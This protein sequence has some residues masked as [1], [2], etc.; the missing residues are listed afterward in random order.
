MALAP[1]EQAVLACPSCGAALPARWRSS[2]RAEPTPGYTRTTGPGDCFTDGV[3]VDYF[4]DGQKQVS[5]RLPESDVKRCP[6]CQRYFWLRS[7][8][9]LQKPLPDAVEAPATVAPLGQGP[10]C[11]T[12]LPAA[13]LFDAI[14]GGLARDRSEETTL[15]LLAWQADNDTLRDEPHWPMLPSR[16]AFPWWAMLLLPLLAALY[17]GHIGSYALQRLALHQRREQRRAHLA[18]A[19]HPLVRNLQALEALL[20]S[21]LPHERLQLAEIAR[22]RGHFERALE[23]L[24]FAFPTELRR[25]ASC[26]QELARRK[27]PTLRRI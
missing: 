20:D 3:A 23:L 27:D 18:S 5:A 12:P 1:P 4:W 26:I 17:L 19:S 7:A 10:A 16:S 14:A 11:D 21:S 15:R 8:Q 2:A 6:A 25:A 24:S 9:V 22:Q 13:S